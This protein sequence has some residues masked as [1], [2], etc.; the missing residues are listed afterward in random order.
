MQRGNLLL[1]KFELWSLEPDSAE[2]DREVTKESRVETFAELFAGQA[3]AFYHISGQLK[4]P[5]MRRYPNC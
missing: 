4:A 3:G 1:P 2:V 5:K